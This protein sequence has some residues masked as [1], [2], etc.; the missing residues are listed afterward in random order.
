LLLGASPPSTLRKAH[1]YRPPA[2]PFGL[3][4]K[5]SYG[6][7]AASKKAGRA[8]KTRAERCFIVGQS[9]GGKARPVH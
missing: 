7:R 9:S 2:N 8:D 3:E 1:P 6:N 4:V 5:S